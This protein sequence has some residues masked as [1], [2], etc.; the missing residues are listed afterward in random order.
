MSNVAAVSTA[1]PSMSVGGRV[2][3][4]SDSIQEGLCKPIKFSFVGPLITFPDRAASKIAEGVFVI[5]DFIF[6]EKATSPQ[7]LIGKGLATTV[8]SVVRAAGL[9]LVGVAAA[10]AAVALLLIVP[11]TLPG[12]AI[13]A[14]LRVKAKREE[15][16]KLIEQ[17]REE[18]KRLREEERQ[19]IKQQEARWAIAAQNTIQRTEKINYI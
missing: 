19:F 6:G 18:Q 9:V 17:D 11:V 13:Y 3:A 2:Q 14:C 4:F 12:V 1:T 8:A 5:T 10:L 16:A 15:E 7:G